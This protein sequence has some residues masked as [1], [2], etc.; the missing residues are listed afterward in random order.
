LAH[1]GEAHQ[2]DV[3]FFRHVNQLLLVVAIFQA[4]SERMEFAEIY[5]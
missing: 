4:V 1:N 3:V 5:K 2:A